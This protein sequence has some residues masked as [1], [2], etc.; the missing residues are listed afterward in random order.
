MRNSIAA[1][2]GALC[3]AL[4]CAC[5]SLGVGRRVVAD[6]AP[7]HPHSV[8]WNAQRTADVGRLTASEWLAKLPNPAPAATPLPFDVT[9]ADYYEQVAVA[10]KL[11]D[12]ERA[13]LGKNG[14]V[15]V[16]HDQRYTF[17]SG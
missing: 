11:S 13:L 10:L 2:M 8:A 17:T 15:M 7:R 16:D 12:E 1:R 4:T 3:L 6:E 14:F 5:D 9:R